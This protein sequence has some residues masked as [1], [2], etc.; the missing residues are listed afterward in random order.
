MQ[1]RKAQ[2]L[3]CSCSSPPI[4]LLLLRPGVKEEGRWHPLRSYVYKATCIYTMPFTHFVC[5]WCAHGRHA[6]CG[7]AIVTCIRGTKCACVH[8]GQA[9]VIPNGRGPAPVVA[10]AA[11]SNPPLQ[12][13]VFAPHVE[14]SLGCGLDSCPTQP[15]CLGARFKVISYVGHRAPERSVSLPTR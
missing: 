15:W 13:L 1:V 3:S 4:S 6:S 9:Y 11:G 7:S 14:T 8:E 10:E 5:P 2:S 12:V